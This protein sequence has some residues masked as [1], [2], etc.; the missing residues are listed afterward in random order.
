LILLAGLDLQPSHIQDLNDELRSE[1]ILGKLTG[2]LARL[3]VDNDWKINLSLISA[4]LGSA[5][6]PE[7]VRTIRLESA[8]H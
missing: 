2:Y 6:Y 4:E 8:F 7:S 5:L 3:R 1:F